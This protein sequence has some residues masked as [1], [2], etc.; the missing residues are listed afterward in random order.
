MKRTHSPSV[1]TQTATNPHIHKGC[2]RLIDSLSDASLGLIVLS[3][4]ILGW[5]VLRASH[6]PITLTVIRKAMRPLFG[7]VRALVY[8][9][10]RVAGSLRCESVSERTSSSNGNP[11]TRFQAETQSP[12]SIHCREHDHIVLCLVPRNEGNLSFIAGFSPESQ[13]E[14]Q[15]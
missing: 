5:Q 10:F 1:W 3:I 15:G 12:F 9:T 13:R 7:L 11:Y 14:S 8:R 4:A 6:L 2:A